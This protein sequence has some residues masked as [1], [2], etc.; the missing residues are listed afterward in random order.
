[1]PRRRETPL[2]AYEFNADEL[3]AATAYTLIQKQ[4]L[5]TLSA[6]IWA[7]RTGLKFDPQKQQEFMQQEAYLRGQLDIIAYVLGMSE[8]ERDISTN[9]PPELR[10]VNSE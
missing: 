1:M 4:F 7:E 3:Q 8:R 5:R 6:D 2:D 10:V 9:R